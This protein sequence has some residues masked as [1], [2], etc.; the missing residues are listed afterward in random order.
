VD[1]VFSALRALLVPPSTVLDLPH[2]VFGTCLT[3]YD[4]GVSAASA[5]LD[6]DSSP[7]DAHDAHDAAQFDGVNG[8][9]T[10]HST[11]YFAEATPV[12]AKQSE[13]IAVCLC[14]YL[15]FFAK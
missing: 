4:A 5:V 9:S 11:E 6:S 8:R 14:L 3:G 12:N 10:A 2:F 13:S 15:Y 1:L 7:A